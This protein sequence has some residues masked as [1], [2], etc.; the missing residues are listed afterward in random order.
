MQAMMAKILSICKAEVLFVGTSNPAT[1]VMASTAASMCPELAV[2]RSRQAK[3]ELRALRRTEQDLIK[4][5]AGA[6]KFH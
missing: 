6:Q 1:D 5:M 2:L 3:R 4:Q